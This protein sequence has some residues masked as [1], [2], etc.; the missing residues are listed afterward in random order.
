VQ[1]P[2]YR[3]GPGVLVRITAD[4]GVENKSHRLRPG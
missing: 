2:R 1:H 3:I 4:T